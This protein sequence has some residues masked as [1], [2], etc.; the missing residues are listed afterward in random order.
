MGKQ[1][2]LLLEQIWKAQDQA[3]DLMHEYDCLPHHYGE[4]VLYQAEGE[5]VALIGASP[6]TT[7]TDLALL[8]KKT[9]SACSQ[10]VRKLREKGLVEQ[11]RNPENN[12]QFQLQLTRDG[13]KVYQDHAEFNRA[14]QRETFQKLAGFTQE[15]LDAHW[16]VQERLNEA[17]AQDVRQS[18]EKFSEEK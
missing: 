1:R 17:Y 15:E 13:H 10:I 8:L 6:D 2:E 18:R 14:C 5:L 9:P 12:R 11:I 3:Y 7:I 16:R 4:D